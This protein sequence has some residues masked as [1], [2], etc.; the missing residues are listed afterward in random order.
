MNVLFILD[1]LNQGGAEKLVLNVCNNI[2]GKVNLF[3]VS[4]KGGLL[5]DEYRKSVKEFYFFERKRFI[6]IRSINLIRKLIKNNDIEIIHTHDSVSGLYAYLASIGNNKIKLIRTFHGITQDAKVNN[7][8]DKIL[9]GKNDINFSVSSSFRTRLC[10]KYEYDVNKFKVLYNGLDFTK[11]IPKEKILRNEFMYLNDKKFI[12]MVSNF[13]IGKDYLTLCKAYMQIT[14]I[15]D[16]VVLFLIG[17]KAKKNPEV[18]DKCKNYVINNNLEDKI[19]FLGRR[20][21]I[22][23]IISSLDLFVFSTLEDTFGIAVI[24][25]MFM[26]I[27]CLVSDTPEMKEI[28]FNGKYAVLFESKNEFDLSKKINELLNKR[29]ETSETVNYVNENYNINTH[30]EK[31]IY[32]YKNI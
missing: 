7:L 23:E 32:A 27:L 30:I 6:D 28:T 18:Y 12:G 5:I 17:G 14:K 11:Y 10:E 19:I 21:D 31:L 24:E 2:T 25:A 9:I 3:F 16:D 29:I 15:R 20:D 1:S 22:P 13:V 4:L 26:G 8:I